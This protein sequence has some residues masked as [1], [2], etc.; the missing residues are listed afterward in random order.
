MPSPTET[1]HFRDEGTRNARSAHHR[2]T[3]A[4]PEGAAGTVAAMRTEQESRPTIHSL[5]ELDGEREIDFAGLGRTLLS[6]WWLVAAAVAAGV[7][8]GYLTSL[9]GGDV[10]VA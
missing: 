8:L 2:V 3:R 6:R 4:S 9:G 10:Y 7:I 5:P 1:T